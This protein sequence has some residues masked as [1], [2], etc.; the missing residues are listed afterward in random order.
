LV[1]RGD[2]IKG[3]LYLKHPR[4]LKKRHKIFLKSIKLNPDDWWVVKDT[5]EILEIV[6]KVSGKTRT[7]LKG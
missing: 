7:I 5:P 3:G 2:C 6:H 4:K 1:Q